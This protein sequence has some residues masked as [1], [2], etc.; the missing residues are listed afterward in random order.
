VTDGAFQHVGDG[1]DSAMRMHGEPADRTF[2]RIVEGEVVEEQEGVVLVA[3]ARRNRAA[4]QYPRAFDDELW[5]DKLVYF[6]EL[7]QFS[8]LISVNPKS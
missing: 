2:E 1:F 5:F 6:S 7:V 8:P 3:A 4:K